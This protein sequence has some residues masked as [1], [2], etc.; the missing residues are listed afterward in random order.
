MKRTIQTQVPSLPIFSLFFPH[1]FTVR[2]Q[3][4]VAEEMG[5]RKAQPR[6]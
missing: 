1:Y 4:E 5:R 3:G 2:G 6:V